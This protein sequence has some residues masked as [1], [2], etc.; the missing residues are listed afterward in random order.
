MMLPQEGCN[1]GAI[2]NSSCQ[3]LVQDQVFGM[4][5]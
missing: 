5:M 1:I 2:E 3:Q 4:S